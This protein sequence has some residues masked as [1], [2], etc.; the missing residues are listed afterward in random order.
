VV[1]QIG[2]VTARPRRTTQQ[3]IA[4]FATRV[5]ERPNNAICDALWK[6]DGERPPPTPWETSVLFTTFRPARERP[7]VRK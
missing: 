2:V 4:I 7:M 6:D 5:I 1:D 3:M